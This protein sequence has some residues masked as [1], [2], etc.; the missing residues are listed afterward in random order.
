MA[1]LSV[2]SVGWTRLGRR[3]NLLE[4]RDSGSNLNLLADDDQSS[5]ARSVPRTLSRGH[6]TFYGRLF[7]VFFRAAVA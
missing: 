4:N 7:K 5:V 2:I 1:G 6:Q 3:S